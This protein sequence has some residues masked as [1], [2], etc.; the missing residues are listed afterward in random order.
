MLLFS[1]EIVFIKDKHMIH[2]STKQFLATAAVLFCMT[3]AAFADEAKKAVDHDTSEKA[4]K[5][6]EAAY[7]MLA[8]KGDYSATVTL[9]IDKPNKPQENIQFKIFERI[10]KDQMTM[11]QLFPEADK[12]TGYLR[13]GDNFWTYDP[14]S[15]KFT[16]SSLKDELGDSDVK[17]DD[18]TNDKNKWRTNFEVTEFRED[19]LGK[20]DVYV[21]SVHAITSAPSYENSTYY[22]R[23]D[24][25]VL[26]KEEDF[27][28]TNRLM[29]TILMPKYTK[30]PQGYVATQTIVRDELNKGEQTQQIVSE[31]TFDALP[32]KIFTKAYLEGLN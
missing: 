7:D 31:L 22:V 14:I 11:V 32:D 10:N 19:K 30:V 3:I 27:S 13:D 16:H 9:V 20:Y 29:R 17:V 26:L 2:F 4:F 12:G 5:V 23:K 24:V 8:Y 25:N 21:V 6:M 28:G 1:K 18:V 15:R